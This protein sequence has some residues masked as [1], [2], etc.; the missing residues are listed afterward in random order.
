MLIQMVDRPNT[1]PISQDR[2]TLTLKAL[3][4]LYVAVYVHACQLFCALY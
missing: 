1:A 3:L 4:Y 2:K